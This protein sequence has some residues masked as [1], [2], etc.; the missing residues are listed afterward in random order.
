MEKVKKD[1]D[2]NIE[3]LRIVSMMMIIILHYIQHSEILYVTKNQTNYV[4]IQFIQIMCRVSVNCFWFISGYYLVKAKFKTE[5]ALNLWGKVLFYSITLL[6]INFLITGK[7][8]KVQKA[9]LPVYSKEYWFIT[10][11]ISIY[12]LL[13]V[14]NKLLNSLTQKQFRYL[15][16]VYYVFAIIFVPSNFLLISFLLFSIGAYIRLYKN[17]YVGENNI[18]KYLIVIIVT[19]II[20]ILLSSTNINYNKVLKIID[21][22]SILIICA[23]VYIFLAFKNLKIT[24]RILSSLIKLFAPTTIAVYIIHENIFS[25]VIWNNIFHTIKYSES[26]YL[27]IHLIISCIIVFITCSI[28]EIIRNKVFK[29]LANTKLGKIISNKKHTILTRIDNM[30][31][32]K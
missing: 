8:Q 9:I 24:N 27:I 19:F 31:S 17:D 4:I 3:L 7:W 5:R 13:P 15:L 14:I 10:A 26:P 28:I 22:E 18:L 16:I 11:Y 29:F 20:Y 30:I 25:R 23:S 32:E 21:F 12:M 2:L 1:R 6:I